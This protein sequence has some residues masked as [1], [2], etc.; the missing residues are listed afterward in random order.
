MTIELGSAGGQKGVQKSQ[1]RASRRGAAAKGSRGA[2]QKPHHEESEPRRER[3]KTFGKGP[4]ELSLEETERETHS[5]TSRRNVL[6]TL[7]KK[8]SARESGR[9]GRER[10]KT[11]YKKRMIEN[12]DGWEERK[13]PFWRPEPRSG[14]GFTRRATRGT[15]RL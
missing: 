4:S 12:N 3:E 11:V 5:S 9:T 10:K 8:Q 14:R 2:K 1:G 7:R 15:E 13:K 6:E